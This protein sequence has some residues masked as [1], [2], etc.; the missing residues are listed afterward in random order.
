MHLLPATFCT[1]SFFPFVPQKQTLTGTAALLV[2]IK[3]LWPNPPSGLWQLGLYDG[4]LM[5]PW[6]GECLHLST[7]SAELMYMREAQ[8]HMVE[9]N[10]NCN[11]NSNHSTEPAF[12]IRI[13]SLQIRSTGSNLFL[14]INNSEW[15][16]K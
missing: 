2:G 4:M 12:C 7:I 16:G 5:E 9:E 14:N 1:I 3:E 15:E 6:R 8:N 10:C 11:G 13:L